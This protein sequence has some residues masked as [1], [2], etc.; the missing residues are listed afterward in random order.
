MT[1]IYDDNRECATTNSIPAKRRNKHGGT[2]NPEVFAWSF[3]RH[4][5]LSKSISVGVN[6]KKR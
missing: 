2:K 6:W 5:T 4:I 1:S 3:L